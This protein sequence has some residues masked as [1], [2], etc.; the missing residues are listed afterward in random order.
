MPAVVEGSKP[1]ISEGT[2]KVWWRPRDLA[3]ASHSRL[4]GAL[5]PFSQS[6]NPGRC[7]LGVQIQRPEATWSHTSPSPFA[8]QP[9]PSIDVRAGR[10]FPVAGCWEEH[11]KRATS[12]RAASLAISKHDPAGRRFRG[13]RPAWGKACQL[14]ASAGAAPL[15]AAAAGARRG[16]V[17][18]QRAGRRGQRR[19]RAAA[20]C[21]AI[22]QAEAPGQ[23]LG[24]PAQGV[25]V[26]V[27]G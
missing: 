8:Q 18:G 24:G 20:C 22:A 7:I 15:G 6:F 13:S 10:P 5:H 4:L 19:G 25:R 17:H 11:S 27:G 21:G 3:A 26:V 12:S 9:A 16:R 14:C 1:S 2:S 23:V